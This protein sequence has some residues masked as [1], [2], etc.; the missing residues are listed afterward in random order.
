MNILSNIAIDSLLIRTFVVPNSNSLLNE[1]TRIPVYKIFGPDP[2]FSQFSPFESGYDI[3]ITLT[4]CAD[5]TYIADQCLLV[6]LVAL[7]TLGNPVQIG[8][9]EGFRLV[10]IIPPSSPDKALYVYTFKT[11]K[12]NNKPFKIRNYVY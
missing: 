3:T 8:A 2:Q 6:E 4:T 5:L 11:E 7:P 10:G 12:P 1:F 9:E